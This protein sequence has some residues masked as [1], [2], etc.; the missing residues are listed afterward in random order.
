MS[1]NLSNTF[2][3]V[4][5]CSLET[6]VQIKIGTLEGI[7]HKIDYEKIL[8]DPMKKFSGLYQ[9][10]ISDL[11]V[12]C[13]VYS[14][15]KPL[16]LPVFTSYK[17]FTNRWSWN[18]WVILP[19]QFSD[20]PRNALLTLTVYDCAGPNTMTAVGGTSIS[21]FGKHGVFRQGM[22][23]LRVWPDREGDGNISVTP[24]KC[25][26]DTNRMQC[27][28]KLAKQ[29]RNGNMP[30]VDWLDR[31]T[32]REIEL[33]NEK[34]K[35]TSNYPYLMIEFPEIVSNGVVYSVVHYEQDGDEIYPFRVNPDIVTVP[36][37]EVMQENLVESKHHK[38]ARS[39]RSG[40]S[41]KDAKPTATVRDVLNTIVGYPPTKTLTTEEQD[42]I[43][44]YRFYL[45]NQKKALTKFLECVN[46]KLHGEA[47]Q[48]LDMMHQWAP[49]DVDDSLRLLSPAFKHLSVRKYAVERL[50]QATDEDLLLYLLQLVQALKYENF[51]HISNSLKLM[52]DKYPVTDSLTESVSGLS[53]KDSTESNTQCTINY[54]EMCKPEDMDLARFLIHRASKNF[55]LANYFYWYLMIECE[56]Q[57]LTIKQDIRVRNMYLSVMKT[58]L[59]TLY[60]GSMECQKIHANLTRQ[61]NF[62]D[63]LVRIVK[64]V[65]RES[66]NRKKKIDKLQALLAETD[67]KFSFISFDPLPLPLD[68]SI[69]ITGIIP[70]KAVLFKS[71][72][73]P[74]RLTFKVQ[75]NREYV[76]IFKHGDDLRQDQ[77]ILQI[78]TLMDKLLRSE[79]LDLKLTPYRVL[80]TSARH[81]F[82]QFVNSLPVAEILATEGSIQNYFRKN[83][84]NENAPFGISV[85]IMENYIKSCAGYCVITYLLGVGDRHF[86]NLLLTSTGKLFHIDFGY[87]LGRDPK[88]LPPPMKLSKEMVEAMG[89]VNSE[90]YHEFR[91]LCYTAFLHLRRHANLILN[92]FSLMVDASVPDIALEPDKTV[93]K[94]QDKFRLDLGD[95]EAVHY[96][97]NLLDVSVTAVMAVLVEQLHK[98]AQYWR[99]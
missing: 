18:E 36:D 60:N 23:D 65:A 40:I 25:L 91:K 45:C 9:K 12:Y 1:N 75:D 16:S 57:D 53:L 76:A 56:D 46:W 87:I 83:H 26:S 7:K 43:W 5:S 49:M 81:G 70:E 62:I 52:E 94:V 6:N 69:L 90:Y 33:I 64:T 39:L 93:N 19:I 68:P 35:K 54:F 72:L 58:F 71:A 34:E 37:A 28:A 92:L 3:Y 98:F 11:I 32:F 86:D 30:E 14:D 96:F 2:N 29:H 79:N 15:N 47:M 42:L 59:M 97:Q 51:E 17:H 61:Q 63:R 38:L 10:P 21:L 48:A 95:E 41:D 44:K 4:Y 24:G 55:S 22:I 77:L 73:M 66:G 88:P 82:V 80:A 13:Q 84:P 27:L 85:D 50:Q 89:G 8:N 31:L 20:L 99:K 67:T 74:S 78:I